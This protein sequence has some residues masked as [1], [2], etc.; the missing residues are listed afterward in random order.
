MSNWPEKLD[1]VFGAIGASSTT[2]VSLLLTPSILL[3]WYSHCGLGDL[4]ST[5]LLQSAAQ[6][7]SLVIR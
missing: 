5:T 4:S 3:R 6:S 7:W 2:W 1:E